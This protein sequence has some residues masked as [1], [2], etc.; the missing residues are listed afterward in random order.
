MHIN[1]GMLV[2]LENKRASTSKINYTATRCIANKAL[3][4]R[5]L[6]ISLHVIWHKFSMCFA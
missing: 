5:R 6:G 3:C 1:N 2:R 4:H